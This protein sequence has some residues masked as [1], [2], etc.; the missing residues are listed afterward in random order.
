MI[1]FGKP[2]LANTPWFSLNRTTILL[3]S[4]ENLT[5]NGL[6]SLRT[7]FSDRL[8][9]R[10][11][12][13]L[14]P[15]L[16]WSVQPVLGADRILLA[17]PLSMQPY[18]I[19]ES[20]TGLAY[21]TIQAAFAAN[22]REVFPVYVS[23]RDL[24]SDLLARHPDIDCAGF[25]STKD[26]PDWFAIDGAFPF[27]D[28][29]VTLAA[30]NIEIDQISDLKDKKII[31]HIGVKEQFSDEFRAAIAE[32]P[33]YREIYNHRAQISL[34]LKNRVQV[35]IADK[36]LVNWYVR[37]LTGKSLEPPELTFHN[38]FPPTRLKFA[39]RQQEVLQDFIGGLEK[40]RRNGDLE[41]IFSRY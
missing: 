17:V 27:H 11:L 13:R 18:F 40:V 37:Y 24:G 12:L 30:N 2:I 34:L 29:A 7:L 25:Q 41:K 3:K 8:L 15:V 10:F 5:Q 35:I 26:N 33:Q 38:L 14:L 28:Y 23:E 1:Y 36:L 9:V 32:N 22:G 31:A 6:P 21:E 16:L 20:G 39:C 4:L 19:V